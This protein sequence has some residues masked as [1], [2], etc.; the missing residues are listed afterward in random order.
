MLKIVEGVP[1]AY[2][3]VDLWSFDLLEVGRPLPC[4]NVRTFLHYLCSGGTRVASI[5]AYS[6]PSGAVKVVLWG[7]R[8]DDGKFLSISYRLTQEEIHGD[9]ALYQGLEEWEK[10]LLVERLED[11]NPSGH[12]RRWLAIK[13]FAGIL[14]LP[15]AA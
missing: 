14:D 1:N 13:A 7:P 15:Y 6:D 10:C 11:T 2:G 3:N 5:S 9:G 8:A 12:K 4:T